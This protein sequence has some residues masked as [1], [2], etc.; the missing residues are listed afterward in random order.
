MKLE[1]ERVKSERM[2]D[3][4]NDREN[5]KDLS[6]LVSVLSGLLLSLAHIAPSGIRHLIRG[7]EGAEG[8]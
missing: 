8:A 7:K 6:P 4:T 2:A 3:F 1:P 5:S